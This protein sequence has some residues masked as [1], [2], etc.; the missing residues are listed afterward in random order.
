[1]RIEDC[2]FL[3][4]VTKKHGIKGRVVIKIDADE[5]KVF[6]SNLEFILLQLEEQ[7][8]S[9]HIIYLT[10][11]SKEN[12]IVSFDNMN[13][14]SVELLI[15]KS[16]YL[17]L[18]SLPKLEGNKFYYHEIIDFSIMNYLTKQTIGKIVSVNDQTAQHYFIVEKN[19][20]KELYIPIIDLWII[21][22]QREKKIIKMELPEGIENL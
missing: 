5:P 15:G 8:V 6:Y 3:G 9:L 21:E 4:K 11:N 16:V 17:P 1:M 7:L 18:S 20:Q 10:W 14:N 22:V 13:F 2:Y 12:M 19:F